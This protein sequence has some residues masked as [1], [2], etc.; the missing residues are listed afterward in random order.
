MCPEYAGKVKRAASKAKADP[1]ISLSGRPQHRVLQLQRMVGNQAVLQ[2][3]AS[4]G[5]HVSDPGDRHEREAEGVATRVMSMRD[6][7]IGHASSVEGIRADRPQGQEDPGLRADRS[8]STTSSASPASAGA[9]GA[10]I[11]LGLARLEGTGQPLAVSE[12]SFFEPRFGASFDAVRI[13]TGGEADRL[14]RSVDARAFTFNRHI[15]FRAGEYRPGTH[16]GRHLLAHELTHTIQQGAAVNGVG[17]ADRAAAKH[18][19]LV[20]E[21]S[22]PDSALQRAVT[23]LAVAGAVAEASAADHFVAPRGGGPVVITATTSAAGQRVS[24]TGGS[25]RPANLERAVPA[26]AARTVTITADTPADP[27]AQTITVHILNGSG[28][29]ANLAAELAFSR[30]AGNP[31]GLAPFG[32]TDVRTNNPVAR[33]RAFVVGNQWVFQV[34]RIA[35]R[36]ILGITGGGNVDIRTAGSATSANHCR[37]ITDL[38]P[39][40]AGVPNGPP[41][42]AFWSSP[43]TLAHE[44]AHVAHFYSPPFWEGFMRVAETTIEAAANN[45][46]VDHTNAA[47]MSEAAVVAG[48]AV[49]NQATIDAQHAAADAAEIGGSEVFAHGQSNPM[50]STLVAQVGARFKPLAPTVLAAVAAGGP[51]VNLTWTHNAC[52]ETEYRV[53]RRRA[54]A[55]F[56]KIATLPAGSVA[57]TDAL[58]G[59]AAGTDFTYFVTAA[60]VAGESAHS[61]QAVVHTP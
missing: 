5:V 24:W 53:Y 14:A 44:N 18:E 43:I 1:P 37:V 29:P 42:T 61:N 21:V 30:Q 41:R 25:A 51:S 54:R 17:R 6:E 3:F 9:Q 22:G 13:H 8:G 46:N 32:L 47:T 59:M 19:P 12:R 40:A 57:F 28:A 7:E 38:T 50:Y 58:A 31:P 23:N 20:R 2:L 36:Y 11:R 26:G 48:G 56:A 55:A 15:V 45:V 16:E 10:G 35:H 52:N 27:G 49:A 33:I 39:P 60:G 4:G 34:Q